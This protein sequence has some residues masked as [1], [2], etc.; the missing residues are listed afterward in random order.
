[1]RRQAPPK[2][3]LRW[4]RKPQPSQ[5]INILNWSSLPTI[6][7]DWFLE[8]C[9]SSRGFRRAL[10]VA[11]AL[12]LTAD[13]CPAAEKPGSASVTAIRFWS[14]GD[15]TRIAVEVS[16]DFTFKSERLVAPERLFFDIIGA[17]PDMAPKGTHII[18]VGDALVVQIRVA[19]TQPDVTRVVL[20]LVQAASV[21]TSQ[22][23]SPNRLMIEL[24]SKERPLPP[25]APSV[26]GGKDLTGPADKAQIGAAPPPSTLPVALVKPARAPVAPAATPTLPNDVPPPARV[27]LT[28]P[29]AFK[30]SPPGPAPI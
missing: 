30:D 17:R 14:L 5:R 13:V 11:G 15:V 23:S 24:R 6:M 26:T 3:R 18:A 1:M 25:S 8:P 22:L 29:A 20:D 16:S 12:L 21:T 4:S 2:R 27:A 7:A 10:F 19:E 28:A 9:S